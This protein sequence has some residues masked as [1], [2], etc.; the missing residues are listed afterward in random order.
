MISGEV[1]EFCEDNAISIHKFLQD[2]FD[3]DS[4]ESKTK[5]KNK[6]W[7]VKHSEID[8]LCNIVP[9]S[10]FFAHRYKNLV[11]TGVLVIVRDDFGKYGVYINPRIF[12]EIQQYERLQEY[13]K[14]LEES[15]EMFDNVYQIVELKRQIADKIHEFEEWIRIIK[16]FG[17]EELLDN[18]A[19]LV[20]VLD[21]IQSDR[22]Q[23][24][25]NQSINAQSVRV[26][27]RLENNDDM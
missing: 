12:Q 22:T 11:S 27:I 25:S 24:D 20:S 18:M 2:N 26:R 3:S 19:H 10:L 14:Q 9:V 4:N 5:A 17:G 13:L 8:V 6:R 7:R 21:E 23:S 1:I 15:P 16:H